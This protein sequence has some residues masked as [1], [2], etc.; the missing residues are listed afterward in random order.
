MAADKAGSLFGSRPR[1]AVL[2]KRVG[3][4]TLAELCAT[5]LVA[6]RVGHGLDTEHG[7]T[8]ANK[9]DGTRQRGRRNAAD[10]HR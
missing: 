6:K 9:R 8:D 10:L 3:A 7:E 1:L 5:V 2:S 4:R